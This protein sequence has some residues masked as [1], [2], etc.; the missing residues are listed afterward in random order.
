MQTS[1]L[2]HLKCQVV[3]QEAKNHLEYS[4]WNQHSSH[5]FPFLWPIHWTSEFRWLACRNLCITS[6]KQPAKCLPAKAIDK[7]NSSCKILKTSWRPSSPCSNKENSQGK[8]STGT[9]Q[10]HRMLALWELGQSL[11][12]VPI[13]VSHTDEWLKWYDGC[14]QF[15]TD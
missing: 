13:P 11:K 7:R 2:W 15:I 14:A 8:R 5:G 4:N 12:S 9:E 10:C 3:P 1:L 6:Y